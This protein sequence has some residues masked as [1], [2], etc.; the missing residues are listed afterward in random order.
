[1]KRSELLN[2]NRA[3]AT[4]GHL[5]GIKFAYARAKNI[6]AI[7]PEVESCQEA[8]QPSKKFSEYDKKRVDVCK[9]YCNKDGDGNPII[10]DGSYVGI[11]PN[12][13]SHFDKEH[14]KLKEE[15]SE[16]IEERKKAVD[17]YN[18]LLEEEVEIEL[19]ML[20]LENVPEQISADQLHGMMPMIEE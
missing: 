16:V 17:E 3:L 12:E 5:K 8:L 18:E 9:E 2:F 6:K 1:M 20:K 7:S 15:Y 14:G 11:E 19:Y 4:V 13:N 10:R